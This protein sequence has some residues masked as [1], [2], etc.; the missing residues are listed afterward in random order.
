MIVKDSP[1]IVQYDSSPEFFA[2]VGDNFCLFFE[3]L[4]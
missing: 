3:G 2:G 4:A 1:P